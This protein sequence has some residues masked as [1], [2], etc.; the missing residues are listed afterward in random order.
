MLLALLATTAMAEVPVPDR[1]E[2][3]EYVV[4][5]NTVLGSEEIERA[6][7][8][9]MGPD[10]S[11]QD[12]YAARDALLKVYQ[13]RGFQSVVVDVPAQRVVDGVVR[14]EVSESTIGRVRVTGAQYTAPLLIRDQVPALAE[15]KV[16]DFNAAQQQLTALNQTAGRQVVPLLRP[17]V[18]PGTLDL[19]LKVE[20]QSP[21][22]GSVGVNNDYSADTE[23]WRASVT[24]GHDNLWQ[25]GHAFSLTYYSAPQDNDQVRV[26]SGNYLAPLPDSRWSLQLSGYK[27]DSEV[28]TLGGTNVLGRGHTVGFAGLY[29]PP[30]S[31][32][33]IHTLSAGID[34]KDYQ[35]RLYFG[36]EANQ[37]PI[38]YAPLV[39]SYNGMH[40]GE[41][42]QTTLGLGLTAGAK[43]LFGYGSGW[44][45][46]DAQRYN[47]SPNFLVF[48]ADF[49]RT[50]TF[51]GGWEL[52]T[53]VNLQAASGPLVSNEQFAIGGA[54][55]VRGYLS[56]EA[57]GDYGGRA[58][59]EARTPTLSARLGEAVDELRFYGFADIGA[60]YLIDPLP[61]QQD[62][63][64]LASVGIGT[65][66]QLFRYLTGNVDWAWA[67]RDGPNTERHDSRL[68]IDV[69]ASF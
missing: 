52:G 32:G 17:G 10:R 26:W 18:L 28:A 4:S 35:Q 66:F 7:Y 12:V 44:D 3:L 30:G 41:A 43:E 48:K 9:H 61:E 25:A 53:R 50:D 31:D 55:S 29:R 54:S 56:A 59:F 36:D 39:L 57:T 21:W 38:R 69:R 33:W 40:W 46:F 60:V 34:F 15:G 68:H 49:S 42:A 22:R 58:S 65:R 6:V 16:P 24:V 62:D 14:L 20:D 64:S 2:V 11:L 27:S 45:E 37:V 63:F 1:F 23:H 5:G 19:E 8:P 13:E 47:A 67:L 51:A